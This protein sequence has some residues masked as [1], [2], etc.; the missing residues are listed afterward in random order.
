MWIK[1]F[2]K[3]QQIEGGEGKAQASFIIGRKDVFADQLFS[4]SHE[5]EVPR[6]SA[7]ILTSI[8]VPPR[9][10]LRGRQNGRYY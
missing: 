6:R 4:V 7:R 9:S 5:I 1:I 2:V 10:E 3:A 8:K